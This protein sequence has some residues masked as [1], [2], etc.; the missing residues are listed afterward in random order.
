MKHETELNYLAPNESMD[1]ADAWSNGCMYSVGL[2]DDTVGDDSIMATTPSGAS[3]NWADAF[4][5]AM[6]L[7]ASVYQQRQ[8]TNLNIARINR[9]QPPLTA[10]EYA[11]V[12]QPPSAQ[13]QIGATQDAK[14]LMLYAALGIAALVGL[15]A[16]KVI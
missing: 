9:N 3:T 10:R 12:Y 2:G 11:S 7:L 16:A 4:K 15:R 13:V 1:D 14:R 6:P 8:M 5:S